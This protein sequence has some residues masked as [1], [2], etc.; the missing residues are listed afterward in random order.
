M[1][2]ILEYII[3]F[4]N[5]SKQ[6][7]DGAKK[8]I[9]EVGQKAE[10]LIG[11]TKS[12]SKAFGETLRAEVSKFLA[13]IPGGGII[14]RLIGNAPSMAITGI[15]VA[16]LG[17]RKVVNAAADEFA[18]F[19][20]AT[21]K[22]SISFARFSEKA[23][24]TIKFAVSTD[25]VDAAI[26]SLR[27]KLAELREEETKIIARANSKN[28]ADIF[29]MFS[30]RKEADRIGQDIFRTSGDIDAAEEAKVRARAADA[31]S[32]R[33]AETSAA[34]KTRMEFVEN[35]RMKETLASGD[36]N[37][38][39]K[40]RDESGAAMVEILSRGPG[41]GKGGDATKEENEKLVKLSAAFESARSAT[42]RL[43]QGFKDAQDSMAEG[44]NRNWSNVMDLRGRL[45]EERIAQLTP[46]KQLEAR[47][48]EYRAVVKEGR[49][50]DMMDPRK[51]DLAN[52]AMELRGIM[53]PLIDSLA[54]AS[55]D[56]GDDESAGG[57]SG[58]NRRTRRGPIGLGRLSGN[59][60]GYRFGRILSSQFDG[61][62]VGGSAAPPAKRPIEDIGEE[63]LRVLKRIEE[64]T[65]FGKG[66]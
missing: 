59:R 55:S 8:E 32:A 16:L 24:E 3:R 9:A 34:F 42:E 7:A 64:K 61:Q 30:A 11:Q 4:R 44:I 57:S 1:N 50:L 31:A 13:V 41:Y 27:E 5:E 29:D 20:E 35:Q 17:V 53:R 12:A 60:A 52:R 66:G 65:G 23:R 14:A 43:E 46:E 10:G 62:T 33:V 48:T 56:G 36:Y 28:P 40:L 45:R 37:R 38:I 47:R 26:S 6:G 21:D 54:G 22:A 49:T 15:S 39:A 18:R 63:Q 58:A 19:A 51:V 2:K 25:Q